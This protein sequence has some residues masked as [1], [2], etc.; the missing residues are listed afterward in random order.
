MC[1]L[2]VLLKAVPQRCVTDAVTVQ[3][4]EPELRDCDRYL[5]SPDRHDDH[6]SLSFE[7]FEV[8]PSLYT[9]ENA[10]ENNNFVIHSMRMFQIRLNNSKLIVHDTSSK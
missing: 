3:C 10:P 4:H 2:Q 5:S 9:L 6:I 1:L 8:A 7:L